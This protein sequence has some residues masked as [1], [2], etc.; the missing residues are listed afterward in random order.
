MKGSWRAEMC[1]EQERD[2]AKTIMK[3]VIMIFDLGPEGDEQ[4]K[5]KIY[6]NKL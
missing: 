5:Y 1:V 2:S 4:A 3:N 6:S